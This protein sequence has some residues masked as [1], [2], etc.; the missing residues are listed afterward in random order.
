MK[1]FLTVGTQVPFDRLVQA[2]ES[3]AETQTNLNILAQIGDAMY[4]PKR[5]E[6]IKFLEPSQ[7]DERIRWAD[8]VV[9]HAGMGTILKALQHGKPILVLPRRASFG[10]QRNDHQIATA[11]K[12]AEKKIVLVAMTEH[13]LPEQLA[14]LERWAPVEAIT[15][16]A[17]SELL[18]T[19]RSFITS[20]EDK[21]SEV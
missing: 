19:I 3:W 2:V 6:S 1:I 5:F 9:A 4:L 21:V 20:K 10:E 13:D 7:F 16:F 8:G 14:M 12:F 15:Q 17:S 18:R 11:R